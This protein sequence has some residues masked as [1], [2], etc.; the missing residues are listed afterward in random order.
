MLRLCHKRRPSPASWQGMRGGGLAQIEA[1]KVSPAHFNSSSLRAGNCRMPAS[2]I[3]DI[4]MRGARQHSLHAYN[5]APN[6]PAMPSDRL[7][8]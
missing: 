2:A 3:Q 5:R 4:G 8:R 6:L 7:S 1:A